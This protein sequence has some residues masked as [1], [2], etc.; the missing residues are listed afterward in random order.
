MSIGVSFQLNH[1][2]V[3]P[4]SLSLSPCSPALPPLS[5]SSRGSC[6]FW[7]IDTLRRW[8]VYQPDRR[9]WI[10][11]RG[12]HSPSPLSPA[13]NSAS[14]PVELPHRDSS[15]PDWWWVSTWRLF[16]CIQDTHVSL[17]CPSS[18]S[19][20]SCRSCGYK[21]AEQGLWRCRSI[22][23][24]IAPPLG[25]TWS[26][27]SRVEYNNSSVLRRQTPQD[28]NIIHSYVKQDLWLLVRLVFRKPLNKGSTSPHPLF[29]TQGRKCSLFSC[30]W[31]LCVRVAPKHR[32]VSDSAVMW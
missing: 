32:A 18:A 11:P 31:L 4:S 9:V 16:S 24:M 17:R 10:S 14:C 3:M 27:P 21:A 6:G 5:G 15:E 26:S 2:N 1:V 28:L 19:D 23:D 7:K 13:Q 8:A 22:W 29:L 30:V 20:S 12:G 25:E